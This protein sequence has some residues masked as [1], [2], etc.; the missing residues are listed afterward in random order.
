MADNL[1]NVQY[2]V[3]KKSK[4]KVFYDS[5]KTII[6]SF[7]AILITFFVAFNFY[8]DSKEKKQVLLSEN[9]LQAK[10]YLDKD[11]KT[12]AVNLLRN[13]IFANDPTYSTLSLFTI[14]NQ[15]LIA[16][17]IEISNLFNHVLEN[18]KFSKELKNL[19]IYKKALF[20]SNFVDE[21]ILLKSLSVLIN[22][23]NIWKPHAIILLGDY[24]MSKGEDVK[25]IEFYQMI[26]TLSNLHQDIYN[27][28]R[29][30]L[31]L[32]SNE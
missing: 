22:S 31:L 3:T 14:V 29:S 23:E 12:D 13:V 32:V 24:F 27:H 20:D 16:D 9:Y 7:F 11:K 6:Y 4:F 18:N 15:N 30:Q 2:D 1:F 19:L 5:Y 17:H 8:L 25:A 26:F 28:A 21:E 10:L